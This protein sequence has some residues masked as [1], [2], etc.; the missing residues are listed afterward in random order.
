[1]TVN[2]TNGGFRILFEGQESSSALGARVSDESQ[3]SVEAI[4][5]V[6][7]ALHL[8]QRNQRLPFTDNG[9]AVM[10]RSGSGVRPQHR[11]PFESARSN[12]GSPAILGYMNYTAISSNAVGGTPARLSL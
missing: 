1:V 12:G 2:R 3:P 4:F 11:Q 7:P 10:R 6:H 5:G 9:E 8:A